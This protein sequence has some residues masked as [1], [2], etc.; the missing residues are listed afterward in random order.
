M[1]GMS[2]TMSP[3]KIRQLLLELNVSEAQIA[4]DLSI[5]RQ[6][7]SKTITGRLRTPWV[8]RAVAEVLG[9]TYLRVWGEADPGT[10]AGVRVDRKDTALGC[11]VNQVID[12]TAITG[13]APCAA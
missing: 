10:P 13:D 1:I 9:M 6:M 12:G 8:R 4:R 2:V 7:V 3:T 11:R 5:S